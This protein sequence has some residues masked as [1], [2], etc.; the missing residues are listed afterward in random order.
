MIGW[1]GTRHMPSVERYT[2]SDSKLLLKLARDSI[3]S[4]APEDA[5]AALGDS[6]PAELRQNRACFV[7]L[8]IAGQLRGCI[9]TL[10]AGLPLYQAVARYACQAAYNDPRFDP[11]SFTET[12]LIHIEISVLTEPVR[13][14]VSGEAELLKTIR[15]D[16]YGL[17]LSL[18]GRQATFLPS[19]WEQLPEPGQFVER[20]KQKAGIAPDFWSD[21]MEC[22]TYQAVKISE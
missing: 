16:V 22:F 7:T 6:V 20:L 9:G 8:R 3:C 2:E 14:N 17:I 19:V 12:A 13:L 11:V 10:K 18:G 1:W 15:P 5:I 21:E 4:A